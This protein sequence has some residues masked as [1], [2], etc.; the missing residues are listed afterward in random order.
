MSILSQYTGSGFGFP[1]EESNTPAGL[2]LTVYL[3]D[4]LARPVRVFA[5]GM[6]GLCYFKRPLGKLPRSGGS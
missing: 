6:V 3:R 2:R 4:N 1:I 5:E